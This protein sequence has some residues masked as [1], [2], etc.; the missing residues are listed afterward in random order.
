[1]GEDH[2]RPD[3]ADDERLVGVGGDDLLAELAREFEDPLTRCVVQSGASPLGVTTC[4]LAKVLS[5]NRAVDRA[6][7]C[8]LNNGG[9]SAPA[10][11]CALGLDTS[12]R[13]LA[14]AIQCA[15]YSPDPSSFATCAA[16]Q[17]VVLEASECLNSRF[18]EGRC[19]G[20][21]N[22]LQKALKAVGIDLSGGTLPARFIDAQFEFYRQQ[23]YFGKKAVKELG[24]FSESAGKALAEVGRDAGKV[25]KKADETLKKVGREIKRIGRKL[26]L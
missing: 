23:L 15:S 4:G 8:V 13:E 16:G 11:A 25:V 1:M 26:G 14:V 5:G 9:P 2:V 18:G 3:R 10:A 22:D 21:N 17:L 12:K 24:R 6:A 19:F 7:L 20:P